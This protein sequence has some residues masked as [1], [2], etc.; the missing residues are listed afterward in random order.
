MVNMDKK[1]MLWLIAILSLAFGM[2]LWFFVGFTSGDELGYYHFSYDASKGLLSH[3]EN[4]HATRIGVI[5]PTALSYILFGVNGF[6]SNALPFVMGMLSVLLVFFLGRLL[7]GDR[8][9]LI[10]AFLMSIY[11]VQVFYSTVLY[12]DLPSA[13]LVALSVYVF[14][15]AEKEHLKIGYGYLAVG[16][17]VGVAY[18]MKE[19]SVVI[20]SFFGVYVLWKRR[21]K[22]DLAWIVV[23]FALVLSIELAYYWAYENNAFYRYTEV[24]DGGSAYMEPL[25][26]N[27]FGEKLLLRLFVHY[28]YFLL[29]DVLSRFFYVFLFFPA[30][31]Y[32]FLNKKK[33]VYPLLLWAIL[34]FALLNFGSA[35]L[36]E[37]LPLPV[38]T[39]YIE[40]ITFPLILIGAYALSQKEVYNKKSIFTLMLIALAM[41]SLYSLSTN[42]REELTEHSR[43]LH[44]YLL[45]EPTSAGK[46]IYADM[47]STEMLK[48]LSSFN[49]ERNFVK[50][51]DHEV[52]NL[53]GAK[54]DVLIDLKGEHG[55]YVAVDRKMIAALREIYGGMKLP[56][57]VE[58]PPKNWE[59]VGKFGE[60]DGQMTLYFI[61]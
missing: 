60:G 39:R 7:F 6:S 11:P 18:L 51:Q 10:A 61:P 56:P 49:D 55:V 13:F 58:N 48:L 4:F 37:Y 14:F 59:V 29:M 12:P 46:T 41:S 2:R 28:P 20:F 17:L 1:T 57:E 50:Y 16:F 30:V 40:V 24:H 26:P 42:G 47:R 45:S 52:R 25:Y 8:V 38:G 5:Y 36:N 32:A 19:L 27:Y 3:A 31:V 21:L 53:D 54:R 33:G 9:G 23:G 15:L 43:S 44:A 22:W 35:S 34:P